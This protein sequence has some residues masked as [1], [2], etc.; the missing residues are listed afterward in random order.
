ML[1]LACQERLLPGDVLLTKFD[2]ARRAEFDSIELGAKGNGQFAARLRE[3]RAAAR[4]AVGMTTVQSSSG[5]RGGVNGRR[6]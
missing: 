1:K 5:V 6:S 4:A 3:L 2:F